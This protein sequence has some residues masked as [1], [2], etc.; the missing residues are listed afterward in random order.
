[1]QEILQINVII[2]Q[3]ETVLGAGGEATMIL[4]HGTFICEIGK[5]RILPGGVD[6]QIQRQG[7]ER[8]LSARYILEGTDKDNK[9][10]RIFVENNGIC[11]KG[12][13][14]RTFPVIYTDREELQWMEREPLTG[15][16]E[17]NGEN[18]VAIKIYRG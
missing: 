4:F 18:D 11:T 6:T 3:V 13:T 1:M 14:L 2:D 9:S 7:K 12:E 10:F 5:G 15:V 17:S 16:V 8:A